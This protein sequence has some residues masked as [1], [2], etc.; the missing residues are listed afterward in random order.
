M[1]LHVIMLRRKGTLLSIEASQEHKSTMVF[2]DSGSNA[3][4]EKEEHAAAFPAHYDDA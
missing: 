2:A 4:Q 3:F 1:S